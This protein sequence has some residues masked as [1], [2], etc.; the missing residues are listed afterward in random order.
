[1]IHSLWRKG[2]RRACGR[3]L[4]IANARARPRLEPLEDRTLPSILTVLNNNDNGPDSLRDALSRATNG[5][6]I[7]FDPGLAGATI[8]L[9][10][11]ELTVAANVV[12]EG[13][14]AD[15]LTVSGNDAS[16]VFNVAPGE[17]VSLSGLTIAHGK[18]AA[19]GGGIWN[20]GRLTLSDCAFQDNAAGTGGALDNNASSG[21]GTATILHCTFTGNSAANSLLNADGGAITNEANGILFLSGCTFSGNTADLGG[22]V[23]TLFRSQLTI[24]DS[25]FMDNT[26]SARGGAVDV[27]MAQSLVTIR[28]SA[29]TGN[30]TSLAGLGTGGGAIASIGNLDV[31]DATF[32]ANTAGDSGF[33]GA[34][35]ND[36]SATITNST[37][38]NNHAVSG[39]ALDNTGSLALSSD[40]FQDNSAASEGGGLYNAQFTARADVHTSTF[41]GNTAL[42]GGAVAAEVLTQVNLDGCTVS[43][44]TANFGGGIYND[45]ATV[46]VSASTFTGNATPATGA[47]GAVAMIFGATTTV[48]GCTFTGNSAGGGGAVLNEG[49]DTSQFLISDS[50]F[51]GNTA[52]SDGGAIFSGLWAGVGSGPFGTVTV[53]RSTFTNNSAPVGGAIFNSVATLTVTDSTLDHNQAITKGGGAILNQGVDASHPG[54]LTVT[55]STLFGN[56]AELEGGAIS[57]LAY[58]ALTVASATID[59]NAAGTMGGGIF[60][61]PLSAA[62][63]VHNT[64]VAGNQA[65][66]SGQDVSGTVQ[67]QGY[68]LIGTSGGSSGWASTDLLGTDADPI[69]PRLGPLQDNGGPTQTQALLADSP[70]IAA[71]DPALLG[72]ADQRGTLRTDHVDMGAFQA[73]QAVS[74]RLVAPAHVLAGQPFILTVVALDA[75]GNVASTFA[76]TVHFTSSDDNA[77][78]PDDYAFAAN[79]GGRHDFS[80]TLFAPGTQTVTVT[81]VND[82]TLTATI[83]LIV[84]LG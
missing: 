63:H 68:N 47:G 57:N 39:G 43:A 25:A 22:A 72:T 35:R 20:R 28:H 73:A 24:T 3:R 75:Q 81:D 37:F 44:N 52:T 11:G 7:T 67:S 18:T 82:P 6:L 77:L 60:L 42:T 46:H 64:I 19:A 84:D 66:A 21:G 27:E 61:S 71:G 17:I 51:T 14:G 12:I 55:T 45:E 29:F 78:L 33:G 32:T 83:T 26:A 13:L 10:S 34:V 59:G 8:T 65:G 69:D 15:Q 31:D 58:G 62:V 50:T 70:A 48:E 41:T 36:G 23:A 49:T 2:S 40:T 54:T 53:H 16:R 38:A 74:F 80:L 30:A 5:D 4:G 56:S 1:M 76:D 79:D 9:T